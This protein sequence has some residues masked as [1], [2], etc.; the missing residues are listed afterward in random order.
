M[1]N[2]GHKTYT[3]EQTKEQWRESCA[4]EGKVATHHAATRRQREKTGS[5]DLNRTETYFNNKKT[6]PEVSTYDSTFHVQEGYCSKLKRDDLQHTQGLNVLAE[7]EHKPVPVLANSVYGHRA[8]LEMPN[9]EHV[10]VAL[11]KREFYRSHSTNLS[12]E[13]Q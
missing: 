10:R 6:H 1:S 4:R 11:V 3:P 13:L 2:Y 9:R 8:P 7:E 5:V 12:P